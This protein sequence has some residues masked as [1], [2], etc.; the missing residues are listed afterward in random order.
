[1]SNDPLLSIVMTTY[2]QPGMQG[3]FRAHAASSTLNSW[4]VNLE[5]VRFQVIVADD[6]SDKDHWDYFYNDLPGTTIEDYIYTL[7]TERLGLGASLNR[8]FQLAYEYSPFVAYFVDDWELFN[9]FDAAPWI[10]LLQE[11][12]DVGMVRL[13]PPHP[14]TSG[15]IEAFTADWQGWGLRLERK[16]FAYA[17][18]PALYHK[19]FTDAYGWWEEGINAL[20]CERLYLEKFVNTP[21]P[22]IVLALPHP[23]QHI[24][25]ISLSAMEPK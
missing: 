13:G 1:M 15:R 10:K 17:Q 5:G 20:E 3:Y 21:G 2:F 8:G 11:R 23:W 24:D 12:E 14:G 18:R 16:G 9:E 7:S 6:G 19:R 4:R 22:D 25:T